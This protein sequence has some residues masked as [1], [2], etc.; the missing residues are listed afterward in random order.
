[1]GG[2]HTAG[3]LE[4]IGKWCRECMHGMES[5]IRAITVVKVDHG[6][7]SRGIGENSGYA[8]ECAKLRHI[9]EAFL[10]ICLGKL[11]LQPL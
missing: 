5:T 9:Y 4:G 1:M 8:K 2:L 3:C 10:L 6:F 7:Y 11:P